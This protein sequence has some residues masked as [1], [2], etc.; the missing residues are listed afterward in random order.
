MLRFNFLP[1]FSFIIFFCFILFTVIGT[2]THEFGHIA[3]AKHLG[4][5]TT[6]SYGGMGYSQDFSQD[7]DVQGIKEIS[8]PYINIDYEEW[9]EDVKLKLEALDKIVME[10]YPYN[11]TYKLHELLITVGGPAQTLLTSF[12]GLFILFIRRKKRKDQFKLVDWLAVFMS[13]FALREVFNYAQAS[14]SA[15]CLSKSSFY[16][17]EFKI[18]RYLGCNEWIIPTI[19]LII[20]LTISFYVIFKI[21]P[22][23]YRFS[24]IVSGLVGGILGFTIWFGFL[25]EMLF[26]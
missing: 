22:I 24:F 17:D 2:L 23:K 16:A 7:E 20:G 21:I 1:R 26:N 9:P 4:Y 6:L 13:L 11:E 18:S 8:E 25:G 15:I 14:Y 3:V 19:S 12:I 10:R 5:E